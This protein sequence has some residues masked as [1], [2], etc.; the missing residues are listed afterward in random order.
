MAL[1]ITHIHHD[2]EIKSCHIWAGSL[3]WKQPGSKMSLDSTVRSSFE[4]VA[5]LMCSSVRGDFA[6]MQLLYLQPL[7][8][9]IFRDCLM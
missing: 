4:I 9:D 1:M 2:L 5:S 3:D 6:A 7:W 8:I